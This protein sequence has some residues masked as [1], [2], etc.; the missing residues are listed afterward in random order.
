MLDVQPGKTYLLRVLN[1]AL[2]YKYYLKIAGHMF[3]V[4]AAD[5][6][7]VNPYTTDILAISPGETVDVLVVADAPPGRYYMVAQPTNSSLS[8]IQALTYVTRGIVQ[9]SD[10][11]SSHGSAGKKKGELVDNSVPVV[12]DMPDIHDKLIS[13]YF[14]G[15]L[16]G[17]D[18]RLRPTMPIGIDEHLF[19]VLGV[20]KTSCQRAQSCTRRKGGDRNILVATMNNI[21]FELHSEMTSLLEAHYYHTIDMDGLGELP[22]RP[23]RAFNYTD[24]SLIPEGPR[25]ALLEQTSKATVARRLRYGATVEVVFQSTALLQSDAHPMHLHGYDMFVVA[26]GLGNYDP[27]KDVVGYNLVNPPLKNTVVVPNLGWAAVRF[28]ADNPGG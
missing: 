20:G 10:S 19:I 7:Y 18:H 4:V 11:H 21:S 16:T 13:F 28:V 15:N 5:A 24:R 22:V 26:Q 2:F 6:N 8:K 17:M 12:P 27:E 1:A 23:P 9:Y 25:E 3:T 14:H